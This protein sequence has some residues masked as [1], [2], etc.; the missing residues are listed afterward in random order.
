MLLNEVVK[1]VQE[2]E[3]LF[4][5]VCIY[6]KICDTFNETLASYKLVKGF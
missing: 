2:F 3:V 1:N 4:M 6:Y 5:V